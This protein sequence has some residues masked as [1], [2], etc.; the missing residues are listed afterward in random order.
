[1]AKL[2]HTIILVYDN[3]SRFLANRLEAI[4][5]IPPHKGVPK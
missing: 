3:E 5:T 2:G 1:M 4:C